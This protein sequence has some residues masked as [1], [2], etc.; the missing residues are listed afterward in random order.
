MKRCV[1]ERGRWRMHMLARGFY[2]C[3]CGSVCGCIAVH[4]PQ[5]FF[6][7]WEPTTTVKKLRR[8]KC[9][10]CC[11]CLIFFSPQLLLLRCTHN[12]EWWFI[13]YRFTFLQPLICLCFTFFLRFLLLIAAKHAFNLFYNLRFLCGLWASLNFLLA[14]LFAINCH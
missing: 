8:S 3:V 7:W 11:C 9:S 13:V 12:G 2:V 10:P 1:K 5:I 6:G 4:S 14:N